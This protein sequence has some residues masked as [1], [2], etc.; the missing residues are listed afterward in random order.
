LLKTRKRW[1]SL[2][3]AVVMVAGLLVPF[4]GTASALATYS[5]TNVANVSSGTGT[6]QILGSQE[7]TFD[8]ATWGSIVSSGS[9]VNNY[10][11]ASLPSSPNGYAYAA[12]GPIAS[13]TATPVTVSVAITSPGVAV[14]GFNII[15]STGTISVTGSDYVA[16]STGSYYP[17][18]LC[19]SVSNPGSI[20][21]G[22]STAT[23]VLPCGAFVPSGVTGGITQ[24]LAAPS[25]SVWSSGSGAIATVGNSTVTMAVES[26]PA[27]SSAGG[28]LGVIDVTE[29]AAGALATTS[30]Q[31]ALKLTLPPGFEWNSITPSALEL[32]WGSSLANLTITTNNN[33][34]REMDIYESSPSASAQFFKIPAGVSV[35]EATAQTGNITVVLA[36]QTSANVSSLVVGSYGQFGLTCDAAGTPPTITAGVQGSTIGEFEVK[37]GIPGSILYGRTITLTLPTNVAWSEYPTLDTN[38]STNIGSGA[39]AFNYWQ[40][41]GTSDN[42]IQCTVG[43]TVTSGSPTSGQSSPGDFFLKNM[44]V[45]PAVDFSGPI[46][47]TVGGS[48][49]LTGTVTLGTVASGVALSSASTPDVQIGTAA[50]I[51][52]DITITE[53]AAGNVASTLYYTGI[54]SAPNTSDY[55]L[56]ETLPG[57]TGTTYLDIVAP[58]GVTFDTTPTVTVTSGNLQLGTATTGTGMVIAG[59]TTAG[60]QGVIQIPID[61]SSTTVSTIKVAAPSVTI[62][63]TVPEGPIT[64]KVEGTAVDQTQLPGTSSSVIGSDGY[65]Y[66]Q[67][68]PND[69]TAGQVA[70]ANVTTGVTNQVYGN[71]VFTIGKTSYTLNGNTVS[72]DVAPYIKDSRT[73]LPVRYVAN[74]LGVADSNIMYDPTTQ[75]VTIIKGSMVVQLTIGSTTMLLNGATITMD[76]A[77]EITSSRTCLPVAWVAQALGASV[78]WN[79]TAQTATVTSN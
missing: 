74:A 28:S 2:L 8:A 40:V 23:V 11:Y 58:V 27:I 66:T 65:T 56:A 75:K 77:P 54:E 13:A 3:V 1:V 37:E 79:A 62:D 69:T 26:T 5:I 24:T 31:A 10:V 33:D 38:L 34:G 76:T 39:S 72:M 68:F 41:E 6:P 20:T 25:S 50:Q 45:T 43:G 55:Q 22:S 9:S 19:I 57:E 30:G 29:N 47:A 7:A 60:N 53:K 17:Q 48:E 32:M 71:A 63:R 64:F 70:V 78:Q 44:E 42:Q 51:L 18:S 36:G 49:G 15:N 16:I 21:S 52:G 46:V 14:S 12:C 4:V 59:T 35:D 61:G 67:V 73:F